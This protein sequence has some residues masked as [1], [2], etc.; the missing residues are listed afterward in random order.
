MKNIC[1]SPVTIVDKNRVVIDYHC[2]HQHCL[3][4]AT[5]VDM[6]WCC[7]CNQYIELKHY[8]H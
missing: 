1:A 4:T 5:P 2:S 7:K 8:W 3:H 6:H